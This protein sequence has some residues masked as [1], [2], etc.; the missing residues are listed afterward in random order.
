[1]KMIEEKAIS[2]AEAKA[3]LEKHKKDGELGY[4][5]QNTLEYLEKFTKLS[6]SESEKLGK[7]LGEL[8]ILSEKQIMELTNN[9]PTKE[10][11]VKTILSKEK[12]DFTS[13]KIKE[14]TKI[15]KKH[16]K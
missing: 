12:L 15:L 10:E 5:Q 3:L 9:L 4:E 2:Y 8:N 1:M 6:E 13:E 14:I 16:S 7:E 11:L